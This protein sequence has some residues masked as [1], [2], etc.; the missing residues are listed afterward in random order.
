MEDC[1]WLVGFVHELQMLMTPNSSLARCRA[2]CDIRPF[3]ADAPQVDSHA[4][5]DMVAWPMRLGERLCPAPLLSSPT[6]SP[7]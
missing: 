7:S 2:A 3:V 4:I 1:P 6:T 5:L